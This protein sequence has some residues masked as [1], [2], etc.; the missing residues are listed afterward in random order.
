MNYTP[1]LPARPG[2]STAGRF[3]TPVSHE[4]RYTVDVQKHS[5]DSPKHPFSG[6]APH[7]LPLTSDPR[8]DNLLSERCF[9]VKIQCPLV[10]DRMSRQRCLELK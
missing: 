7:L 8:A 10:R 1:P 2:R 6:E 4:V 3:T 5:N 9:L